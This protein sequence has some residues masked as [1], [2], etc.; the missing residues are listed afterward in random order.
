MKQSHEL[1]GTDESFLQLMQL[2]GD[3]LLKLLGYQKAALPVKQRAADIE[4]GFQEIVLSQ[5]SEAEL[6]RI[7]PRLVVLAP[8]TVAKK[9]G[10]ETVAGK[11]RQWRDQVCEVYSEAQRDEALGVLGLFLF[12]RFRKLSR[13]EVIKMLNLEWDK[14]PLVQEVR[15]QAELKGRL[16]G[17][18]E[19]ELEGQLKG[20]REMV[21]EALRERFAKVPASLVKQ[22]EAVDSTQALKAL[23]RSAIHCKNLKEFKK[24][25]ADIK[26]QGSSGESCQNQD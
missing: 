2:T 10:G 3:S 22:V 14:N 8:F 23:L 19:G 18:I 17:K 24:V 21:I 12:D 5:Y 9:A 6:L 7:D 1:R 4:C 20:E 13:T 15:R 16:E 26:A 25:L 11:V